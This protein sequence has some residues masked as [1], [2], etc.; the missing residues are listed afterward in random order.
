MF[1]KAFQPFFAVYA[2]IT[3]GLIFLCAFCFMILPV[4]CGEKERRKWVVSVARFFFK[5]WLGVVG[6]GGR[7]SRMAPHGRCIY[8]ANHAS[9]LDSI[10]IFSVIKEHFR[11]LG[12]SEMLQIPLY[13]YFYRHAAI[14]VDRK[15]VASRAKSILQMKKHLQDEGSLLIFPEGT[16]NETKNAL[17]EFYDGAFWLA[18][19]TQTPIVPIVFPDA[20]NRWHYSAW[21]KLWPGRN[22]AI[23]LNE[24]P[25]NAFTIADVEQ[26]KGVVFQQMEEALL[27]FTKT[28]KSTPASCVL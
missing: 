9:Y 24:I 3:Y 14:A 12:K 23:C 1:K 4:G 20:V 22:R 2:A 18:I 13:G 17:K 27:Q 6:M 21:W 8:V 19:H 28:S 5:I 25:V 7:V 11:S 15:S 16:F 10:M 26:L